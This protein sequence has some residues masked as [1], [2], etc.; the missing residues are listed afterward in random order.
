VLK[1][2]MTLIYEIAVRKGA[3]IIEMAP[4]Q[5]PP[6]QDAPWILGYMSAYTA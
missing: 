1:V 4:F 3:F 5:G 2:F 6:R